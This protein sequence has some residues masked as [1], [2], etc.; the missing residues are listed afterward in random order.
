MDTFCYIMLWAELKGDKELGPI[1]KEVPNLLSNQST[2]SD[3]HWPII[4]EYTGMGGVSNALAKSAI[5]KGA[6][7][8]TDQV[9]LFTQL[10]SIS[11]ENFCFQRP[12]R[13]WKVF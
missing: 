1:Q 12:F 7:I 5:A 9:F 11:N 2:I 10:V 6:S 4:H 3:E 13:K 8:Y